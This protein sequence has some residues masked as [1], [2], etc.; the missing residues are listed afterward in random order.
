MVS[1]AQEW[2]PNVGLIAGLMFQAGK[3][4][5]LL[6]LLLPHGL[7]ELTACSSI[8]P[9][10]VGLIAGLMFQAG[11]GDFLLGLLLPHGLLELT[12]RIVGG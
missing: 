10:N 4:D 12:A 6:G 9:P 3:G 7:L 2:P 8:T 1:P 5:F 11:K